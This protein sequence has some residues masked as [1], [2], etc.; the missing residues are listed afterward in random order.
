MPIVPP[1]RDLEVGKKKGS[2][3]ARFWHSRVMCSIQG[4]AKN[5]PHRF[6]GSNSKSKLDIPELKRTG[7]NEFVCQPSRAPGGQPPPMQSKA[8]CKRKLQLAPAPL[9]RASFRNMQ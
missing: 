1:Y 3:S 4:V 8:L 6:G 5:I 2:G 9:Q 7:G